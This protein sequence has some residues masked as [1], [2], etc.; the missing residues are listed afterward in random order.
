MNRKARITVIGYPKI[1][2]QCQKAAEEYA[3]AADIFYYQ[4]LP[5]TNTVQYISGP[6]TAP[7]DFTTGEIILSGRMT[8]KALPLADRAK[9]IPFR[10][11][12]K[13][14]LKALVKARALSH[15][16]AF[17]CPAGEKQDIEFYGRLVGIEMDIFH[18]TA[19]QDYGSICARAK[20][21]GHT[22]VIS[23]SYTHQIAREYG[24]TPIFL[25]SEPE[26]YHEV[27]TRALEIHGYNKS[28]EEKISLLEVI[29]QKGEDSLIFVD[30]NQRIRF[31]ENIKRLNPNLN[32]Q[33]LMGAPISSVMDLKDPSLFSPPR[34][35]EI[36]HTI[37]GEE[38]FIG[39][40]PV[41]TGAHPSGT[42][43]FIKKIQRIS[44]L[45]SR[46]RKKIRHKKFKARHRFEDILGN[47]PAILEC[48]K[49]ARRYAKSQAPILLY[50]KTGTGKELFAQ[51]IH[52]HSHRKHFP[53]VAINCA[54]LP[55][56]LME[57]ELFGYV[58]G[59]FSGARA[60]GKQ[61]LVDKA[62]RGTLFLDEV[63]S[64]PMD[65][66]PKLL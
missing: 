40:H 46:V 4:Y 61:G 42:A 50:G 22:L 25:F 2:V 58:K 63:D 31:V 66:Q 18:A 36:I 19:I 14:I 35:K 8:A 51:S 10:A 12:P 65:L 33:D 34:E 6:S 57:S 7:K 1:L 11:G 37:K 28:L 45:D 29:A 56:E 32:A 38:V 20:Q 54:T 39:I 62:H 16:V 9:V 55:S 21:R 53:F 13:A 27:F 48:K 5:E 41:Q 44:A 17:I 24:L 60:Q 52:N 49:K 30:T 64:L 47:S 59:A 43:L 3:S 26:I 15:R 23:G